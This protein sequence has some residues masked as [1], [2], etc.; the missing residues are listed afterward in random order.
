MKCLTGSMKVK[1]MN[2]KLTGSFYTPSKLVKYMVNEI[3]DEINGDILEPS[4]GDGRFLDELQKYN[5]KKIDGIEIFEEKIKQYN[6]KKNNIK[7]IKTDFIEFAIHND[8]KYELIIGNPPYISKKQIEMSQRVLNLELIKF[9]DIT[10]NVFQNLW[11]SFVLGSIKLLKNYGTIFYVLPFE[12]LQVQYAENLR[13]YLETKF[14]YIKITTFRDKVFENIEQDICLVYLTNKKKTKPTI[15]Y[16]TFDNIDSL[17]L[18]SK[19]KISRNKPLKKWS[20]SI[21]ND[22]ET[23]FLK[24]ISN[25]YTKISDIGYISPGIVTGANK[26]FILDKSKISNFLPLSYTL[27]I[28]SKASMIQNSLIFTKND[29]YILEK[30]KLPTRL[31]NLN[32]LK[33]RN[34]SKSLKEYLSS[35]NNI[36]KRYKCRIRKRWYDVPII[37]NG[38]L[39]FFKRYNIYPK[40]LYN[41][42]DVYTTDIAYNIR[43]NKKF[44]ALSVVFCFY[45]SLTLALCEYNGRFYGGGV[46]ELV[47]SEFKSLYIPYKKIKK[48]YIK[49]LDNMFRNQ[50]DIENIINFVDSLVFD[51]ISTKEIKL[52]KEIRQ[53]YYNRRLKKI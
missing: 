47:P 37:N 38:N 20:N 2:N 15:I 26:F 5:F 7:L 29:L 8:A 32:K 53:R 21:L 39:I 22:N 35:D 40:F 24:K 30:E 34:F 23:D 28:L 51:D 11:V 3:A 14:N 12:F 6:V 13:N 31:L 27:P 10:E 33:K 48:S 43:L 44:D 18:L 19:S 25:R 4:F 49:Q 50:T 52:L 1:N 16:E 46:N 36:K 9:F 42:A 17:N 45:N 41:D